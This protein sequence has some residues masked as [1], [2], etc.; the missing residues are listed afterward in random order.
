M[1]C[2]L[3]GSDGV[4]FSDVDALLL[5][6]YSPLFVAYNIS[7][8]EIECQLIKEDNISMLHTSLVM[9]ISNG[10]FTMKLAI[11]AI[12]V[13]WRVSEKPYCIGQMTHDTPSVMKTLTS[14][15]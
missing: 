4:L 15:K 2:P 5:T 7:K 10:T 13:L 14:W 11:L 8:Y 12:L 9:F 3:E 6:L 1:L